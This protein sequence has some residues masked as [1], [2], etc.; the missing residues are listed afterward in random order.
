MMNLEDDKENQ[1]NS[2]MLI[3]HQQTNVENVDAADEI[4][5]KKQKRVALRRDYYPMDPSEFE[6]QISWLR[7]TRTENNKTKRRTTS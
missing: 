1:G 5:T 6:M 7:V 4:E 2:S 3:C